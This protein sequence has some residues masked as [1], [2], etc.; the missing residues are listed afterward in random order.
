MGIKKYSKGMENN[1]E[2]DMAPQCKLIYILNHYNPNGTEHFEHSVRFISEL[3]KK[4]VLVTLVVEKG[5]TQ[6]LSHLELT[7]VIYLNTN[8][9]FRPFKLT[10][11]LRKL[12]NDQWN[13]VYVRISVI[14]SLCAIIARKKG[15]DKVWFWHSG[16]VLNIK[17]KSW[18]GWI[19]DYLGF[20]IPFKITSQKVDRFITGPKEMLSYYEEIGKV[21]RYKLVMMNNDVQVELY[22]SKEKNEKNEIKR[23]LCDTEKKIILFVHRFSPVRRTSYYLPY[24]IKELDELTKDNYLYAII[25]GGP[26]LNGI[27]DIYNRIN[28]KTEVCWLNAV[29]SHTVLKWFKIS[30]YFINPSWTEGFPRVIIEAMA[31]GLPIVATDAG[32]TKNIV[33]PKQLKYICPREDRD[34]FVNMLGEV[35]KDDSISLDLSNENQQYVR[36]YDTSSV[37]D[38]FINIVFTDRHIQTR[39]LEI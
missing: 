28:I 36:R 35:L 17:A 21:P 11:I 10:Y 37:A 26:E 20:K 31:A 7:N 18:R 4:N 14:A 5:R 8:R 34:R 12:F 13:V 6:D 39:G 24:I 19:S 23:E 30:D 29:P 33:G 9:V 1:S 22:R 3:Q 16:Q 32:G 25:G 2:R 15:R 38:E 27:I